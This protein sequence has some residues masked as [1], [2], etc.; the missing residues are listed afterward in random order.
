MKRVPLKLEPDGCCSDHAHE[1]R[2][3]FVPLRAASIR[4]KTSRSGGEVRDASVFLFHWQHAQDLEVLELDRWRAKPESFSS[5]GRSCVCCDSPSPSQLAPCRAA[6]GVTSVSSCESDSD[7][8]MQRHSTAF[9]ESQSSVPG[10]RDLC[11]SE[12]RSVS[13][14]TARTEQTLS[15]GARGS[16]CEGLVRFQCVR[17]RVR[18]RRPQRVRTRGQA[19]KCESPFLTFRTLCPPAHGGDC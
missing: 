17:G 3:Q 2:N 15:C 6:Q 4:A 10:G 19:V 16:C 5:T 14:N 8:G 9:D 12:V 7:C 11:S 1:L 18:V 13:R